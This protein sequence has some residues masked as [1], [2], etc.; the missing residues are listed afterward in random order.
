LSELTI[1]I[2]GVGRVGRRVIDLL[3]PFGSRILANDLKPNPDVGGVA[4]VEKD[5]IYDGA[6]VISLHLPLT[7]ATGNLI[8]AAELRR[9]KPDSV[10]VNTSRGGIVNEADLAAAL[11][12]RQ[13][14]GAAI[15]VFTHEPYSGELAGID[16]C[17]VT[18]HMGSMSI[19]CRRRM[20]LEAAENV[21]HFLR[22]GTP[23]QPVP[24]EEYRLDAARVS[25]SGGRTG[26]APTAAPPAAST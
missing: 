3:A 2:I 9:L 17:L 12:G 14:A 20:E 7:A 6:D 21:L 8:A 15:D 16:R 5:V 4:W 10:L 19:D 23:R 24:E 26:S 25:V 1:G 11:R 22:H 18:C 13:I